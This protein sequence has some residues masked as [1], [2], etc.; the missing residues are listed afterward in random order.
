CRRTQC[1]GVE[2]RIAQALGRQVVNIRRRHT[3]AERAELAEARVIDQDQQ[4]VWRALGWAHD[5]WKNW[6]VR[7]L[8]GAAD[9]TLEMKIGTRKLTRHSRR[10]SRRNVFS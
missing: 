5:L 3:A 6:R 2:A 10:R 8:E 9:V 4:D 7:V 1:G